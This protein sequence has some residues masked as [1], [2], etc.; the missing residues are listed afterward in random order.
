MFNDLYGV[1]KKAID[2]LYL[3]ARKPRVDEDGQLERD[4]GGRVR[5]QTDSS[6]KHIE[7]WS[8][9]T[10]QDIETCLFELSR[11]KLELAPQLNELLLEAL[12]AKHVADDA[13]SDAFAELIDG[14]IPERNSHAA[15]KARQDKYFS[16]FRFYLYSHADGFMKELINFA[17]I[18]ERT[19][20]W[21]IEDRKR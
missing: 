16:Y 20:Q 14:T 15:R 17:R 19:R 4:S 5:W 6:G 2:D 12:F 7:D 11:I 9:L 10:G 21:R 8:R 3:A 18:L 13:F 1:A